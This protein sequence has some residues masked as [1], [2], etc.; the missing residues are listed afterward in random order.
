MSGAESM[1]AWTAMKPRR[2][3][4]EDLEK[5][6]LLVKVVDHEHSVGTP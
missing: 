4:V 3:M 2:A 1:P 5:Q 6:G